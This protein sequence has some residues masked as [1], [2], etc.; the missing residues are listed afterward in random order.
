MNKK[1]MSV[2]VTKLG[3]GHFDTMMGISGSPEDVS[4]ALI[5]MILKINDCI[6]GSDMMNVKNGFWL[7]IQDV[8]NRELAE[9]ATR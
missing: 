9:R 8:V 7:L 4:V 6:N 1:I 5:E 2:E 3:P